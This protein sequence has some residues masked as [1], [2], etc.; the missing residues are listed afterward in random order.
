MLSCSIQY[1]TKCCTIGGGG[2]E[3]PDLKNKILKYRQVH[4]G[5]CLVELHYVITLITLCHYINYIMPGE[6]RFSRH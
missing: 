2:K 4:S 1:C 5:E 3:N 6:P